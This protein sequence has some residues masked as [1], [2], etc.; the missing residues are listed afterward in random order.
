M[1]SPLAPSTHSPSMKLRQYG[2]TVPIMV[3]SSN[4]KAG[5]ADI[6]VFGTLRRLIGGDDEYRRPD[7]A[8]AVCG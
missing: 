6:E 1:R 5:S 4:S 3:T 2:L 8:N 7:L